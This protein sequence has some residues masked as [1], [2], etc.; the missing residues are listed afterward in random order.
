MDEPGGHCAECKSQTQKDEYCMISLNVEFKTVEL[1][2]A[3]YNGGCQGLGHMVKED[4]LIK[5]T[6]YELCQMNN[7]RNLRFSI[8]T[9]VNNAVLYI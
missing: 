4:L 5:N 7:S 8:V 2:S 3:E 9:T 6:K 1:I